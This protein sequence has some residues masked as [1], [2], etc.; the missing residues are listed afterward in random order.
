MAENILG[1]S[2]A[3]EEKTTPGR[4]AIDQL[5][6]NVFAEQRANMQV[7][8]GA[9][10]RL[11]QMMKD[12]PAAD[13]HT[14]EVHNHRCMQGMVR[15]SKDAT[16]FMRLADSCR[17]D[18]IVI[19]PPGC[20]IVNPHSKAM[21]ETAQ[22]FGAQRQDT[23]LDNGKAVACYW[24]AP[25]QT[26]QSLAQNMSDFYQSRAA[27]EHCAD[28]GVRKLS[29]T[30]GMAI[31][32]GVMTP[33]NAQEV[34]QTLSGIHG[35]AI[36]VYGNHGHIEAVVQADEKTLAQLESK[37]YSALS[38]TGVDSQ[39][40]TFRFDNLDEA[41]KFM[42]DVREVAQH[43]K[44]G[45]SVSA[46]AGITIVKAHELTVQN[47]TNLAGSL[48]VHNPVVLRSIDGT[49][50]NMNIMVDARSPLG[51]ALAAR[52]ADALTSSTSP[53]VAT[54]RFSSKADAMNFL[55]DANNLGVQLDRE[56]QETDDIG[57]GDIG[58]DVGE[59]CE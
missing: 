14:V 57:D 41:N 47:A 13:A 3:P 44:P 7:P 52:H 50:Q 18:A 5:I 58:D 12:M 16:E 53:D 49:E 37:G 38:Q 26:A 19:S 33:E 39:S 6:Y 22:R 8:P 11:H 21:E 45:I 34:A 27:V 56:A 10:E 1:G 28:L 54:F 29:H 35:N 2:E 43:S 36:A 24:P 59:I 48:N 15:S 55:N 46:Q 25:G 31:A 20:V 4:D 32:Q 9:L 40:L 17:R 42:S 51:Q 30:D 23:T